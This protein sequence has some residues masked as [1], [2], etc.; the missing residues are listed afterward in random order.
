MT[1]KQLKKLR[2]KLG[3]TQVELADELGITHGAVSKIEAG[4]NKI[5]KPV[6]LLA[7]RLKETA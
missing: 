5:S 2:L 3:M 4:I 6:E 7:I 1:A